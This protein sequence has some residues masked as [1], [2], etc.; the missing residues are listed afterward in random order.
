MR[1]REN[2]MVWRRFYVFVFGGVFV[3]SLIKICAY[4]LLS[5]YLAATIQDV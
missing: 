3:Q 1:N 4:L 2:N 5:S